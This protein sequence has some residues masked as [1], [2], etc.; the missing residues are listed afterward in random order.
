MKN[1]PLI[2]FY[3]SITIGNSVSSMI[4]ENFTMV[5]VALSG[6]LQRMLLFHA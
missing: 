4:G 3:R 2:V 5:I 6:Q 1:E